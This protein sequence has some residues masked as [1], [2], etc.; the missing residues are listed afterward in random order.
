MTIQA[1]KERERLQRT[2]T[3]LDT[4]EVLF[5]AKGYDQTTMAAIAEAAAFSKRTLYLYFEDKWE[6][7]LGIVLRGQKQ[8]LH[9][10]R[11]EQQPDTSGLKQFETVALAFFR[12]GIEQPHY[13]EAMLTYEL[14]EYYYGKSPQDLPPYAK[15]CLET[16]NLLTEM[17]Q[18]IVAKGLRDKSINSPLDPVQL[19]FMLWAEMVGV[20]QV[21]VKRRNLLPDHYQLTAEAFFD[22]YMR[23]MTCALG[24]CGDSQ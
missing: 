14:R 8:L 3:F 19:T 4:A 9:R 5:F 17:V 1:R 22:H 21:L 18:Q 20:V 11:K 6:L 24:I 15:A 13:F 10:L 7:Y 16:N 12:F 23:M 2:E